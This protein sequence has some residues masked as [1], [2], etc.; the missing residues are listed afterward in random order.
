MFC[1]LGACMV[2]EVLHTA[3]IHPLQIASS[4]FCRGHLFGPEVKLRQ[5]IVAA[6][7]QFSSW[8]TSQEYSARVSSTSSSVS[9]FDVNRSITKYIVDNTHVYRK[10]GGRAKISLDLYKALVEKNLVTVTLDRHEPRHKYLPVY[11]WK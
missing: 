10:T 4:I 6:I 8:I 5:A 1:G 7:G 2:A 11:M 9:A 3:M